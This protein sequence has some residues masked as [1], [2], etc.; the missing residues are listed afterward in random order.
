MRDGEGEWDWGALRFI[1]K[2]KG[3]GSLEEEEE[4]GRG[5]VVQ[6]LYPAGTGRGRGGTESRWAGPELP[7]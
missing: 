5:G 7:A 1:E 3:A 2:R 6:D 4:D